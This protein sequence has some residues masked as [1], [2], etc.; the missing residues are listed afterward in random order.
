MD[1]NP[2]E[3]TPLV[4]WENCL[5]LDELGSIYNQILF[6]YHSVPWYH[7]ILKKQYKAVLGTLYTM[8]IWIESNKKDGFGGK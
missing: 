4:E 2:F 7:C 6:I 5:T 3:N 8:Y 1:V